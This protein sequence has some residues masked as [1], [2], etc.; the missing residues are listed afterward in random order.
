MTNATRSRPNLKIVI[1]APKPVPVDKQLKRLLRQERELELKL[2]R[3]RFEIGPVKRAY[4]EQNKCF[5]MSNEALL[6][7]L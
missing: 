4:L 2:Q 5:G 3:V 1:A 6:K 7:T